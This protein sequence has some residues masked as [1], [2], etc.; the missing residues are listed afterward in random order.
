MVVSKK[1]EN[2][3]WHFYFILV[4]GI[5][6][7]SVNQTLITTKPIPTCRFYFSISMKQNKIQQLIIILSEFILLSSI[8][9]LTIRNICPGRPWYMWVFVTKQIIL[10]RAIQTYKDLFTC[11]MSEPHHS[12]SCFSEHRPS[13]TNAYLYY[14]LYT[15]I[16]CGTSCYKK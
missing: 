16:Q 8:I 10:T 14:K 2:N 11:A 1:Y 9:L 12:Y 5:F 3:S 13:F 7:G 4:V 15:S 6:L